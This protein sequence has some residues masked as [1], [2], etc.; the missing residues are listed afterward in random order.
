VAMAT[1]ADYASLPRAEILQPEA[2]DPEP[3]D[4]E[5]LD[6]PPDWYDNS[7]GNGSGPGRPSNEIEPETLAYYLYFRPGRITQAQARERLDLSK[8]M[9][10]RYKKYAEAILK[11]IRYLK[12]EGVTLD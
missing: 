7:G 12:N 1:K 3:I 8:Y 6:D 11:T 2:T 9:H 5:R 4:P 10:A